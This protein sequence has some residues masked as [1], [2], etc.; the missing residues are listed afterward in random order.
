MGQRLPGIVLAVPCKNESLFPHPG[1]GTGLFVFAILIIPAALLPNQGIPTNGGE[2]GALCMPNGAPPLLPA[3]FLPP[4]SSRGTLPPHVGRYSRFLRAR[5][6]LY[7]LP[8]RW[9]QDGSFRP[10]LLA[11]R[12]YS[13]SQSHACGSGFLS[14][15]NFVWKTVPVSIVF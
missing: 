15:H 7:V 14:H 11:R 4:S 5:R 3:R 6:G 10:F 8:P 9:M 13:Q 1:Q 12:S 2:P